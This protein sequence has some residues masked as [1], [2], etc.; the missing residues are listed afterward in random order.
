MTR[1]DGRRQAVDLERILFFIFSDRDSMRSPPIQPLANNWIA[2]LSSR[3]SG[4]V[5]EIF[6]C[7]LA[8]HMF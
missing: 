1:Y 2:V 5:D 3:V 8:E 4:H 7:I 6:F